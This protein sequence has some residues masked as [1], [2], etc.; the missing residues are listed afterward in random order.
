VKGHFLCAADALERHYPDARFLTMIREPAPRLQS[1][2]NYL[3]V[4]P[5]DALGPV[6]W[7][8][9]MPQVLMEMMRH[10]NIETTM[11]YYVGK[12]AQ[13]IAAVL[14]ESN[15]S[16]SGATSGTKDD[17]GGAATTNE[18]TQTSTQ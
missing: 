17:N 8:W 7:V 5:T 11:R 9:L 14:W 16:Q 6:P 3:R 18:A 15:K 12:Y 4:N 13:S 10:E 2:I 1:G